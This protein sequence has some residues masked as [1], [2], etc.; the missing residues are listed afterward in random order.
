VADGAGMRGS[1]VVRRKGRRARA[2]KSVMER[3]ARSARRYARP[4]SC[5]ASRVVKGMFVRSGCRALLHLRLL[6]SFPP[7]G[8]SRSR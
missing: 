7:I 8:N 6:R 2:P 3:R 5:K 1:I 4:A